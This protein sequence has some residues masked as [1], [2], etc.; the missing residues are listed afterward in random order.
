MTI[1]QGAEVDI[2]PDGTLDFPDSVLERLDI[3][4]TTVS[5]M[6]SEAHL[7]AGRD[8]AADRDLADDALWLARV[9]AHAL[10]REPEA[11]GLLSLLLFH[12]ARES[13]RA[14]DGDLVLL[15]DQDRSRWDAA[16]LT[17]ARAAL[18]RAAR[19]RRSQ[20]GSS[21]SHTRATA[22]ARRGCRLRCAGSS[23]SSRAAGEWR[24]RRSPRA[25][26]AIWSASTASRDRCATV[27]CSC[28]S[29]RRRTG[30]SRR[31]DT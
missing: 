29:P 15:D 4:L 10:P 25:T 3:V 16:M 24:R 6:Y 26:T 30:P 2:L 23:A 1:L 13:A 5:V 31:W 27:R 17:G 21:P 19:Q 28:R 9:I 22:A 11:Q 14:V 20:R 18:E 7:V 8:A 12:R